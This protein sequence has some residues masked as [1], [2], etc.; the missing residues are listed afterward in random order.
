M[1]ICSSLI[2]VIAIFWVCGCSLHK[3]TPKEK[4]VSAITETAYRMYLFMLKD[5]RFPDNLNSLPQRQ[6]YLNCT[7]DGWGRSLIYTVL[8]DKFIILVSL[9]EDGRVGGEG[10]NVDLGRVYNAKN[11]DGTWNVNDVNW[12]VNARVPKEKATILISKALN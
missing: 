12:I 5:K 9:G 11:D 7:L 4:T 1:K 6:N 8:D 10:Q 3:L 2:C